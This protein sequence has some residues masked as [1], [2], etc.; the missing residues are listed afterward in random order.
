MC[1]DPD[2]PDSIV[3]E[4]MLARMNAVAD[5]GDDA[6]P[7]LI[8]QLIIEAI[9]MLP[10]DEAWNAAK[11][12]RATLTNNDA[13]LAQM[14]EIAAEKGSPEAAFAMYADAAD[15]TTQLRW[16]LRA[17]RL[18]HAEARVIADGLRAEGLIPPRS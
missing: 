3:T 12:S 16:L 6:D 5:Q 11:H 2:G 9:R 8:S 10:A 15:L 14:T 13:L 18:D 7:N 17:D 4:A 1:A